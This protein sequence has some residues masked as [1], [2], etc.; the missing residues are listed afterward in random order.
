MS[1]RPPPDFA[2]LRAVEILASLV[3]KRERRAAEP[4]VASDRPILLFNERYAFA[5]ATS[6]RKAVEREL[7]T[8]FAFPAP[9]WHS[10]GVRGPA[11]ERLLLSVIYKDERLVGVEH[12][13]PKMKSSPALEPRGLGAFRFVPGEI[14]IG[15]ALSAIRPPFSPAERGPAHLVYAEAYEAH[16]A[17]GLAYAMGND[18]RVE[19]LV[20]YADS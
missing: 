20:I 5:L 8:G 13:L 3:E 1:D 10:Y 19:R 2:T 16:F 6:T 17:G 14:G 9:G 4:P 15:T 7:G 11:G 12:Y 18:G